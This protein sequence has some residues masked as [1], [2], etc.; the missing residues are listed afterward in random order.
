M[1]YC[2]L[3]LS[4][5]TRRRDEI[6]EKTEEKT[7]KK[8]MRGHRTTVNLRHQPHYYNYVSCTYL[9]TIFECILFGYLGFSANCFFHCPVNCWFKYY[10]SSYYN[11]SPNPRIET[12][13]LVFTRLGISCLTIIDIIP[14]LFLIFLCFQKLNHRKEAIKTVPWSPS[15]QAKFAEVLTLDYMSEE[16][17]DPTHPQRKRT[18]IPCA[19]ESPELRVLKR[20]LDD[21]ETT[22]SIA[23][24]KGVR[25]PVDRDQPD[26]LSDTHP[27]NPWSG[28]LQTRPYQ[29]Y[30][31]A[32]SVL[33]P[34]LISLT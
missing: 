27:K 4:L 14:M 17:T 2:I 18:V 13:P 9:T 3:L 7:Q 16:N 8:R 26:R 15:I 22:L 6:N 21:H 29:S 1:H 10:R 32:L 34:G 30:D 24:G 12:M 19:W 23:K 31:Q 11:S 28:G 33:R 25:Q 20:Q 5:Q